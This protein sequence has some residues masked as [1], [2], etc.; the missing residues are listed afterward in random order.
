MSNKTTNNFTKG[1]DLSTDPVN[2]AKE[3][4]SYGLNGIKENIINNPE[5]A[6]NEKGFIEYLN[7]GYEYVLLGSRYFGK[8]DYLLFIKEIEGSDIKFNRI[9]LIENGILTKTVADRIDLNFNSSHPIIS[10]YRLNYKNQRIVY[11]V[12]G[13]ND[14]RVLNIDID[15]TTYDISL[16]SINSS[17]S[18]PIIEATVI[19]NGGLVTSGQYFIA[20]SYNLGDTYT[21]QPLIVSKPIS[22]SSEDY[23][24]NQPVTETLS[25]LYGQTDGDILPS[26]TR[27]SIQINVTD[28]DSNFDS[29]NIIIYRQLETGNIIRVIKNISPSENVYIFTGSEGDLDD[30]ITLNDIITNSINYYASEAIIQKDNRLLRGNSKLKASSINYQ[31]YAN[32]IVVRYVIHE[33]LVSDLN[34]VNGYRTD[35]ETDSGSYDA[36]NNVA[37]KQ[38]ISPSY[39][40]NTANNDTDNK[41]FMRD[42]LY[43]LGVGFELIDGTETDVFHVPARP[44]NYFFTTPTGTGEYNRTFTPTWDND[45]IDGQPR[46]KVMNTAIKQ[47]PL[48]ELAYWR[49]SETYPD[50]YNY[51]TNGEKNGSNKSY[52]RHHKMPSDILEPIYRT[53]IIGD[54][55]KYKGEGTNYKL[56]KR[57]LGL[58]FSNIVIP[59]E[60]QGLITKVKFYYTP[61]NDSNKSILSKGITYKLFKSG[62]QYDL[63][64]Y[65]NFE[66][67]TSTDADTFEFISPEVNFKFKENNLSGSRIKVCGI[68]KG[69]VNFVGAKENIDLGGPYYI[70]TFNNQLFD[71]TGRRQAIINPVCF[72]NQRAIP[73]QELYT[74]NIN[75][76]IYVDGNYEGTSDVGNLKFGSSQPTSVLQLLTPLRLKPSSVVVPLSN[77]YPELLYPSGDD[78]SSQ[79]YSN[80]NFYYPI[81]LDQG[82]SWG[83]YEDAVDF[84]EENSW[85]TNLYY[86]TAYYVSIIND[87]SNLY[88]SINNLQFIDMGNP[89]NYTTGNI[90][91]AQ[92]NGGDTFIDIH[93]FRQTKAYLISRIDGDP[94]NVPVAINIEGGY[95]DKYAGNTDNLITEVYEI[96]TQSF[97][98]FF[99]ETDINI[100]MRREGT[101]DDEKYFPKSYYIATNL[102]NYSGKFE[103]TEFYKI[104]TP[105]NIQY[106]KP[107]FISY[108]DQDTIASN[109]DQDIRYYTR[110]VYSD[111]QNLED[112]VDNYRKV[113]ANNYRDL[114]LD[115][116]GISIFFVNQEKLYTITRDTIFNVYTSNQSL[117]SLSD[118]NITVG[119]GEFL[120]VEPIDLLSIDGG[121]AGTTSKLSFVESPYG[122]L[123]V[124]RYKGKIILFNSESTDI[125]IKDIVEF[126]RNNYNIDAID[127]LNISD[128]EFDNPLNN[129]GYICGF[130][131]E[132]NRFLIT[133]KDYKLLPAFLDNYKG[134]FD[135][136]FEY[137]I[138]D[139]YLKD[140][141]LLYAFET[142]SYQYI[143]LIDSSNLSDF[144]PS[145]VSD[146]VYS[147]NTPTH[148]SII[149]NL[150]GTITYTPTTN[151]TGSDTFNITSNCITD[152][153][154]III[155]PDPDPII[156]INQTNAD[157]STLYNSNI[158]TITGITMA[159]SISI[160]SGEYKINSGAWTNVLGIVNN[161]DTVQVRRIS[162][163]AYSTAVSTTLTVG[164][165]SGTYTITTK[166]DDTPNP[167]T[168]TPVVNAE[169]S[170]QYESNTIT[171]SGL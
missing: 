4:Y 101:T 146:I 149:N 169:L 21:T 36:V 154:N 116:G 126:I 50:N 37:K 147:Y 167:F 49:S 100:R 38:S 9:L 56:Y 57:N 67:S 96:G 113:K 73:K 141:Q 33:E 58:D 5:S 75:K 71:D 43:S 148:G 161:G 66:N 54:P 23:Y 160:V 155:V 140:G 13:L 118:T 103:N 51:P 157:L 72:Y 11:W 39:L 8:K 46:W 61:R 55:N 129:Y 166:D 85:A 12:D 34:N 53:E 87:K 52:I 123:F 159:T 170:T 30:T 81:A 171:I 41:T 10:T 76:L 32:N 94:I 138:G 90:V 19:D 65:L 165:V 2:Q 27:K 93:H 63:G 42:E 102:R 86:D 163:S 29:Y 91:S 24:N 136:T 111:K 1:L 74:R 79:L 139:I 70:R 117:Q 99:C 92:I 6:S 119:T 151:Y 16:L 109:G 7:L 135:P 132:L 134:E 114:P 121:Y 59:V 45:I 48:G 122:Y 106:I 128:T 168:F 164:T 14:D 150:D 25:K 44:L 158:I 131:A 110:I 97:G 82:S 69:Y 15:S 20:V 162:S 144:I 60:L 130:D 142:S 137:E 80:L 62:D 68:D 47:S 98:S 3:S 40:A 125:A 107:Y 145:D 78:A 31:A 35:S 133:K 88:G 120:G 89:I 28:I 124:D 26:P 108:V 112:K 95:N 127:Q 18:K 83:G 77:Y 115:K 22:I 105:Y 143:T 104:E 84:I 152:T 64:R 17:A 153:I 156:F